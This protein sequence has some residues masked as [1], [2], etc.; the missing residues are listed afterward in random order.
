MSD[1]SRLQLRLF[2]AMYL[3]VVVGLGLTAWPDII[4]PAERAADSHSVVLASQFEADNKRV[5][6]KQC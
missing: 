4:A 5:S 1:V 6:E 2:R 3:L